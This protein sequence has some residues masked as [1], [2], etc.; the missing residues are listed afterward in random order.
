MA[1]QIEVSTVDPAASMQAVENDKLAEI[2]TEIRNRLKKQSSN[3]S[4]HLCS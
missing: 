1:D 3:C 4:L 2:A